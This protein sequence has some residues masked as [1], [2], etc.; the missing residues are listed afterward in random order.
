MRDYLVE[1]QLGLERTFPEYLAKMQKVMDEVKRVLKPTGTAWVNMGDPYSKSG[2]GVGKG[3]KSKESFQFD[4]RPK[5]YE[6]FVHKCRFGLP[7]RFYIQCID[8]GWV[9]RNY[10]GWVKPNAKPESVK[11]RF[12]INWESVFFFAKEPH[13]YFDLDPLR[14]KPKE[15][16]K[17]FNMRVR[18]AKQ[19]ISQQKLSGGMSKQEDK[20]YDSLGRK[21]KNMKSAR[22]D[23]KVNTMHRK[24]AERKCTSQSM[25][26]NHSGNYD[27]RT[28]EALGHPKGK[29]PGAI[30]YINTVP[31]PEAHYAVF[32]VELP[33]RI[34]TCACPKD[35]IV[36]D[37]FFGAGTTGLAAEMLGLKWVGIELAPDSVDIATRRLNKY[38]NDHLT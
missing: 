2:K 29:N 20:E 4:K 31:F 25:F 3:R 21:H 15:D 10:I 12:F 23:G 11:D 13:Y 17:P 35:G 6:P 27:M 37:P 5:I 26:R 24:R 18:D 22:P 1:G 16:T 9:A 14:E 32:P 7:E 38:R 36:L 34:L 8:N 30:F 19:G 33:K 28:G